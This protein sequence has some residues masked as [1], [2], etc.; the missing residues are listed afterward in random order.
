MRWNG[1]GFETIGLPPLKLL[2][3]HWDQQCSSQRFGVQSTTSHDQKCFLASSSRHVPLSLSFRS[4]RI[5]L[6]NMYAH[7]KQDLKQTMQLK[8]N[9][10]HSTW[11]NCFASQAVGSYTHRI[12][13]ICENANSL[14]IL[15]CVR[16]RRFTYFCG[17]FVYFCGFLRTVFDVFFW[18][19]WWFLHDLDLKRSKQ[20]Y[21]NMLGTKRENTTIILAHGRSLAVGN[22]T[23]A[24][25]CSS[26][27]A[28][29]KSKLKPQVSVKLLEH[30]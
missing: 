23:I 10:L 22:S 7:T 16:L 20:I 25:L 13:L 17:F 11:F 21:S 19:F 26:K 27:F 1:I 9:V 4:K 3:P 29:S 14:E 5:D 30:T 28:A 18:R 8:V 24:A 2:Q 12:S 6:L 15:I